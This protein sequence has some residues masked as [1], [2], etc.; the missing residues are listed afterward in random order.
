MIWISWRWAVSL[1]WSRTLKSRGF[2]ED[3]VLFEG[4][5]TVFAYGGHGFEMLED[6][7]KIIESKSG[8]F[9]DVETDKT[10]F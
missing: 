6:D 1:L 7:T 5:L 2:L 9:T 3:C 8:P 4:D 10:K